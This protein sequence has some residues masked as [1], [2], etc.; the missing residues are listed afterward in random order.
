MSP[1]Y[2]D[3]LK[4]NENLKKENFV[5]RE[6]LQDFSPESVLSSEIKRNQSGRIDWRRYLGETLTKKVAFHYAKGKDAVETYKELSKVLQDKGIKDDDIFR[7]MKI[8]VCAR[9]GEICSE[10]DKIEET[11]KAL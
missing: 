2:F 10:R 9:F 4:E 7:R 8:G 1:S 3:L 5:L 6:R 11:T